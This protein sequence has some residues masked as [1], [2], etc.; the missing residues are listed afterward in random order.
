MVTLLIIRLFIKKLN[1]KY[2]N[3]V[4]L[5]FGLGLTLIA[6]IGYCIAQDT[7]LFLLFR[8]VHGLGFGISLTCATA[9]SNE[10]VPSG[11]MSEG[12]G[13]TSSANT[14]ANA[15]GPTIAMG[16]LGEQYTNFL[17]LFV[18]LLLVS[19][20]IFLLSFGIRNSTKSE[21]AGH[22]KQSYKGIVI[23]CIFFLATLSQSAVNNFLT[24]FAKQ[25]AFGNIGLF[26]TISAIITL[27]SRFFAKK[28]QNIFGLQKLSLILA[29]LMAISMLA[30]TVI[31]NE[32]QLFL[33]AIPYGLSTGLLF[34]IFNYRII[35]TVSSS[36]L[37]F[38]TSLYYC[39]L[40]IG[41]GLGAILWGYVGQYFGYGYIYILAAILLRVMAFVNQASYKK[42]TIPAYAD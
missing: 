30:I 28:L 32:V 4:L 40:D 22:G 13:F 16:I 34:P 12:V 20:V 9:I 17:L 6:A 25:L 29:A 10:C 11:R 37:A 41:Y 23:A 1:E 18:V 39:G 14:V 19:V 36:Q 7:I 42:L 38:A 24:S 2:S 5:T 26:F 15:I 31:Q 35:Q 27:A 3:K 8:M 21:K 33:L